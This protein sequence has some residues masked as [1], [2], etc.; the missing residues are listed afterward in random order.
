MELIAEILRK[1]EKC[2]KTEEIDIRD[3][4]PFGISTSRR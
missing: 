3:D 1:V 2:R 4:T